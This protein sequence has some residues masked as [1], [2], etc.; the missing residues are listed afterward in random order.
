MD[1]SQTLSAQSI[2]LKV[3]DGVA[4]RDIQ[5]ELKR[6]EVVV[7]L[8]VNGAGKS[9]LLNL[10][11]GVLQP[12]SGHVTVGELD[13]HHCFEVRKQLGYL[14]DRAPL[15]EELTIREQLEFAAKLFGIPKSQV[16]KRVE[17]SLEALD[18]S[19]HSRRL[20]SCLS[21]GYRQR[22]G[23]AQSMIHEPAFLLLDEPTEGLDPAQIISLRKLLKIR[24]SEG[25][26]ILL[27]THLLQEAKAL[28]DRILIMHK[29][30]II[31]H[32]HNE[33]AQEGWL[34]QY[35][36]DLLFGESAA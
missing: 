27:S 9:T 20:I 33:D 13:I 23:I 30:K 10:M 28:A 4:I 22:C 25:T 1:D 21:K 29:G 34:E 3:A 5:L 31:K 2:C 17:F 35:F 16:D 7:L 18:L 6:G 26:G 32:L 14:P 15:Y 19:H 12:S 8:G 11:S 36:T 24:A